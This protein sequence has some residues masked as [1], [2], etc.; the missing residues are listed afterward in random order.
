MVLLSSRP[1]FVYDQVPLSQVKSQLAKLLVCFG[2]GI[3]LAWGKL[4][5]QIRVNRE[6]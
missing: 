1:M 3:G 4:F 2:P 6:A 5:F